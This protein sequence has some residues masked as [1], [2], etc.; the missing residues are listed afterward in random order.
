MLQATTALH[1]MT[2][3]AL[4]YRIG[5][6]VRFMARSPITSAKSCACRLVTE[7]AD[8]TVTEMTVETSSS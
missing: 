7:T 2:L 4:G 3:D 5:R 8:K 1:V 6:V